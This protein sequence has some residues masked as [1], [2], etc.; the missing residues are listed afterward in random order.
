MEV[1]NNIKAVLDK[2]GFKTGDLSIMSEVSSVTASRWMSNKQQPSLLHLFKL[3]AKLECAISDLLVP[4]GFPS[5]F[6]EP[7]PTKDTE[8]EKVKKDIVEM[9]GEIKV[10][11]ETT[12]KKEPVATTPTK[13][14]E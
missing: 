12:V 14:K 3:A 10:L 7:K 9:K 6:D 11:Q 4:N 1:K 2:K 13:P 8:L 5:I